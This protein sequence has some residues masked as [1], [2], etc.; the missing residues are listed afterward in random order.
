MTTRTDDELRE[1]FRPLR[2]TGVEP[3]EI[4]AV[5]RVHAARRRERRRLVRLPVAAATV[6]A[7]ALA[8]VALLPAG[9]SVPGGGSAADLLRVAAARAAEQAGAAF[10]GYRYVRIVDRFSEPQIDADD[11]GEPQPARPGATTSDPGCARAIGRLVREAEREQWV[12]VRWEGRRRTT[13]WRVVEATPGLRHEL[14]GPEDEPYE[15]GDGPLAKTDL[16]ELPTDA[17]AL[18]ETLTGI[19]RHSRGSTAVF[20]G[21]GEPPANVIAYEVAHTTLHLIAEARIPPRLRA[22]AWTVLSRVDG[23]RAT[24][25]TVDPLGRRG[26]AVEIRV[27]YGPPD[28]PSRQVLTV[29]FDPDSARLLSW[30]QRSDGREPEWSYEQTH[31]VEQTGDVSSTDERP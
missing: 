12:D 10:E 14:T 6:A 5:L 31:V 21:E 25:E 29:V 30:S 4:E 8:A 28:L 19:V 17:D 24:G 7:A 23:A 2:E 16:E 27:S 1:A 26:E 3:R 15:Y 22:A 9:G 11:C 20:T 13:G 18:E